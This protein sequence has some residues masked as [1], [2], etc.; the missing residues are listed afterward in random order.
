MKPLSIQISRTARESELFLSKKLSR[1]SS[2]L[3]RAP[4]GHPAPP[5]PLG[6]PIEAA[7][8]ES[9][10]EVSAHQPAPPAHAAN[11]AAEAR[12]VFQSHVSQPGSASQG[13]E[14]RNLLGGKEFGLRSYSQKPLPAG[15]LAAAN[16]VLRECYKKDRVCAS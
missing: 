1:A 5:A 4:S 15:Y 7:R 13:S 3:R 8:G 2:R 14:L 6:D 16:M 11:G 10:R 9:G 12:A